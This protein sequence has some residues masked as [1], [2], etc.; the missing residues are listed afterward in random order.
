[1]AP[2]QPV[3]RRDLLARIEV[4][5]SRPRSVQRLDFHNKNPAKLKFEERQE[6]VA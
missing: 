1:M 6:A 3:S 2:L 5:V 4:L